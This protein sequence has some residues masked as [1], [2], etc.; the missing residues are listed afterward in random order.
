MD[1]PNRL[2]KT[3]QDFYSQEASG[4]DSIRYE[5]RSGAFYNSLVLK[6]LDAILAKRKI[7]T[8]LDVPMGTGRIL[9]ALTRHATRVYGVDIAHNMLL[10]AAERAGTNQ[11]DGV[12]LQQCSIRA[13]PFKSNAFD[14]VVSLRFL[15]LIFKDDYQ[16]YLNELKR[17]LKPNGLLIVEFA[18]AHYGL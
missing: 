3:L 17:V 6:T 14:A 4:Y 1:R 15:H 8:I 5:S 2:E 13:L 11:I 7:F 18:N 12:R 10:K 16:L 9:M